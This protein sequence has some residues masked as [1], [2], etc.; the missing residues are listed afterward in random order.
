MLR[1][2]NKARHRAVDVPGCAGVSCLGRAAR[3]CT[4]KQR[5]GLEQGTLARLDHDAP[6]PKRGIIKIGTCI[7]GATAVLARALK[8]TK[9]TGASIALSRV[10][11][12]TTFNSLPVTSYSI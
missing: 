2:M 3:N 8:A 9:T 10:V 6:T 4:L 1:R 7:G 5:S 11:H 12:A